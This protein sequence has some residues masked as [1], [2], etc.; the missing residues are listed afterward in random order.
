MLS[1]RSSPSADLSSASFTLTLF[2]MNQQ[3]PLIQRMALEGRR[4]R[5][6]II[7]FEEQTF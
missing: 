2:N 7:L 5:L 4:P 3:L 6:H 1:P